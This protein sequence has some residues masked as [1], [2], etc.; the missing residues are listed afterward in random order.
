MNQKNGMVYLSFKGKGGVNLGIL[1]MGSK[2]YAAWYQ[3]VLI[4]IQDSVFSST[5]LQ[6][7]LRHRILLH[8]LLS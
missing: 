7:I 8:P 5:V 3:R 4:W 6:V 2:M 1:N